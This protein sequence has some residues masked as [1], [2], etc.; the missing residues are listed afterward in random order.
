MNKLWIE[1]RFCGINMNEL[2]IKMS[3][4]E[5][6][7]QNLGKI[8][9]KT[10]YYVSVRRKI[11]SLSELFWPLSLPRRPS[12]AP[13]LTPLR[14]LTSSWEFALNNFSKI[15]AICLKKP[16]FPAARAGFVRDFYGDGMGKAK[17]EEGRG[18]GEN[19]LEK[20]LLFGIFLWKN[21][22]FRS[23]RR[24]EEMAWGR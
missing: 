23:P 2:W 1:S 7:L 13:S 22:L 6:F 11:N 16:G 8:A 12:R 19:L 18:E 10:S 9:I 20:T 24:R 3:F 15:G 21:E 4:C 5:I 14:G 17:R